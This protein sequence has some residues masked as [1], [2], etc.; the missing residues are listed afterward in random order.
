M[1]ATQLEQLDDPLLPI[2]VPA[3]QLVQLLDPVDAYVPE[4]H[5]KHVMEYEAPTEG[6]YMPVGQLTQLSDPIYI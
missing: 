6:Q 4:E 1:P 3:A 5:D 2:Y